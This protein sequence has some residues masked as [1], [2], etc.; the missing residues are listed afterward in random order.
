MKAMIGIS[1]SLCIEEIAAGKVDIADVEKIVSGSP[2]RRLWGRYGWKSV[3][4]KYWDR[5]QFNDCYAILCRL[6]EA[7]KIEQPR[8]VGKPAPSLA[9]LGSRGPWVAKESQIIWM[10]HTV[11]YPL[12]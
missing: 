8:L 7:D 9:Y 4:Q 1:A 11:S 10:D 2:C 12:E 6:L 5:E 3:M